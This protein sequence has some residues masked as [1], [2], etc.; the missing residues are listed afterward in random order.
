MKD[1]STTQQKRV[2]SRRNILK[3]I[4]NKAIYIAASTFQN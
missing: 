3:G 4:P 1:Q 2:D